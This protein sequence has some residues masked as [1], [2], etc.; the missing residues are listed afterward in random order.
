M[1][2]FQ[3]RLSDLK[4]QDRILTSKESNLAFF[5]EMGHLVHKYGRTNVDL[6]EIFSVIGR[7]TQVRKEQPDKDEPDQLLQELLEVEKA[8]EELNMAKNLVSQRKN[9]IV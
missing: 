6:N 2:Q 9:S 7:Q 5:E 1:A 3:K 8:L 4:K